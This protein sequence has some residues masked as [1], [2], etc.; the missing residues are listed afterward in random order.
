MGIEPARDSSDHCSTSW[1]T[2][3][4]S[5]LRILSLPRAVKELLRPDSTGRERLLRKGCRCDPSACAS[6][7]RGSSRVVSR[8]WVVLVILYVAT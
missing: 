6:W 7:R 3:A 2:S 4:E 5:R 1:A 8:S